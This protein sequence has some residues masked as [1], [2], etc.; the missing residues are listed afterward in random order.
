MRKEVINL[1]PMKECQKLYLPNKTIDESAAI[2]LKF[3]IL[4]SMSQ[5]ITK[6]SSTFQRLKNLEIFHVWS[7]LTIESL[8]QGLKYVEINNNDTNGAVLVSLLLTLNIFYTLF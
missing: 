2:F 4:Y 1:D 7:K 5:L 8:E 3:F 6:I